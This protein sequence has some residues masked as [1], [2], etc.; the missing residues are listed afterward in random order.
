MK[1]GQAIDFTFD[2]PKYISAKGCGTWYSLIDSLIKQSVGL[3]LREIIIKWRIT[4]IEFKKTAKR[5][6]SL[7]KK[8]DKK[9]RDKNNTPAQTRD[10]ESDSSGLSDEEEAMPQESWTGPFNFH[11]DISFKETLR[12]EPLWGKGLTLSLLNDKDQESEYR[13]TELFVSLHAS[14]HI[15]RPSELIVC[16]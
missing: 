6:A 11:R 5:N 3:T 13:R 10:D 7:K 1:T 9:E 8:L 4:E 2:I 14:S 16:L 15:R 12:A